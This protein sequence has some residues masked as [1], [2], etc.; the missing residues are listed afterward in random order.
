M[1]ADSVLSSAVEVAI[2]IA[3]FAGIVAAIR[4]RDVGA[5]S[6]RDRITLQALLGSSG[7]AIVSGVLPGVLRE[8]LIPQVHVW[9]TGSAWLIVCFVFFALLR[10]RQMRTHGLTPF[11]D[12]Y[13]LFMVGAAL[14]VAALQCFNLIRGVSWPYLV[15]VVWLLMFGFALFLILLFRPDER[16]SGQIQSRPD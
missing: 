15:A 4:Q 11:Q 16:S 5:W 3:G 8:A 7:V 6:A 1:T 13:Y 10:T 14:F 12:R 9:R 2:G